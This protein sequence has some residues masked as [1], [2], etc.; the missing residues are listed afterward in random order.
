MVTAV[1]QVTDNGAGLPDDLYPDAHG[2]LGLRLV[3][4]LV[5]QIRGSFDFVPR[6]QGTE[7]RLIFALEDNAGKP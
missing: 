1:L 4:S 6:P 3:R 5:R 7:A 2:S